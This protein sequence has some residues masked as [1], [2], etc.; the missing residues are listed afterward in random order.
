M[1]ISGVDLSIVYGDDCSS[2]NLTFDSAYLWI[3]TYPDQ[4]LSVKVNE[5]KA[6]VVYLQLRYNLVG[7][8]ITS[9][10]FESFGLKKGNS[11]SL[12]NSQSVTFNL[13][14]DNDAVSSWTTT[15]DLTIKRICPGSSFEAQEAHVIQL[16]SEY[17]LVPTIWLIIFYIIF[18]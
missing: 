11:Y 14:I 10:I 7:V 3:K 18:S 2:S 9:P 17:R 4:L 16:N 6:E 12:N 8:A 13:K 5:I 15:P 1:S